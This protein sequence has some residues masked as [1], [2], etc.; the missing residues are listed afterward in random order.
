MA[1]QER[2]GVIGLDLAE[3]ERDIQKIGTELPDKYGGGSSLKNK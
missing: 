1:S 3:F 2:F